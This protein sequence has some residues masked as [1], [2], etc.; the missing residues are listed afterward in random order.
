MT[1]LPITQ[2]PTPTT[3]DS[4]S[5]DPKN[6]VPSLLEQG[7]KSGSLTQAE[8]DAAYAEILD[9]LAE[10]ILTV[11]A[12]NSTSV[13]EETAKKLLD[14]ILFHMETALK[15]EPTTHAALLR[16]QTQ[17]AACVYK[18]GLAMANRALDEACEI[19]SVLNKSLKNG[20]SLPYKQFIIGTLSSYL[21][22]YDHR[23]DPKA[24]LVIQSPTLGMRRLRGIFEV[25]ALEK[26]LL[27][28][29]E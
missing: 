5:V 18:E 17:R 28:F 8:A 26:E 22:S 2:A 1:Q 14:D 16:L 20:M 21:G 7:V 6:Y 15:N 11:S 12:G 3:S 9:L 10:S 27:T 19:W 24:E 23:F 29:T 13:K 4:L 25:L